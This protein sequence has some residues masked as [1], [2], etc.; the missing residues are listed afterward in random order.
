MPK[1]YRAACTQEMLRTSSFVAI[2]A[3]GFIF[4]QPALAQDDADETAQDGES[5]IIVTGS[6]IANVAPVGATVTQIGREEIETGGQVTL[7][8]IIQDLPQVLDQVVNRLLFGGPC[9][10]VLAG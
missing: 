1:G 6:R 7:D 4:A 10:E 5:R 8:K 2:I 9:A 3:A